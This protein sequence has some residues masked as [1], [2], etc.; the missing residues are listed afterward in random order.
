[1]KAMKKFSFVSLM[2]LLLVQCVVA[3]AYANAADPTNGGLIITDNILKSAQLTFKSSTGQTLNSVTTE[4]IIQVDYTWELLNGHKYVDGATYTFQLPPELEVYEVINDSPVKFNGVE[5]GKFSVA[6]D[7]TAK[8]VFNDFIENNSNIRG[9]LQVLSKINKTAEMNE[10]K[11]VIV[12]PIQG[13]AEQFIPIDFKPGGSAITKNWVRDRDYNTQ[14]VTWTIDLNRNLETINDAVLS[15]I[16]DNPG[17]VPDLSSIVVYNLNS[18]VDG[19]LTPGTVTDA[20]YYEVK[21]AV[22]SNDFTIEFKQPIKSAYRIVYDTSITNDMTN[23][24]NTAKLSGSNYTEQSID[25]TVTVGRGKPLEKM[26]WYDSVTQ[27]VYW[28]IHY[29]YDSKDI[30]QS[31]ALLKDAFNDSNELVVGSIKVEKVTLDAKGNEIPSAT[32]PTTDYQPPVLTSDPVNK[33]N[34]FDLQFNTGVKEPIKITYTTRVKDHVYK[35]TSVGNLVTMGST[36][37]S[38]VYKE[39]SIKQQVLTKTFKSAKYNTKKA[40][41]EII[42]NKAKYTMTNVKLEDTFTNGG[43][44][45]D[46]GSVVIQDATRGALKAGTDYTVTPTANGFSIAFAG[47][48]SD[49]LTITY[50]T[51]FNYDARKDPNTKN[52][53]NNGKF[54]WVDDKGNAQSKE[55]TSTFLPDPYTLAN[56]FKNGS[57]NAESKKITWKIGINYNLQTLTKPSVKDEIIG[58]QAI[59]K[60]SLKV[61]QVSLTGDYNGIGQ[62]T[63]VKEGAGYMVVWDPAGKPGFEVKFTNSINEAYMITYDTSLAGKEI[64]SSYNNTATLYNND[65][66]TKVT[67]LI[68]NPIDVPKGGEYVTKEVQQ[69]GKIA[70]WTININFGQSQV[71]DAVITDVPSDNQSL[72]EDSFQLSRIK[73]MANGSVD[74]KTKLTKG[75]D[76]DLTFQK[77]AAGKDEFVLAFKQEINEPYILTYKSLILAKPGEY[78]SNSVSFSGNNFSLGSVSNSNNFEVKMTTGMGT[79]QGEVGSLTVTKTDR[80]DS[81]KYLEGAEFSLVDA[82]SG[83]VIKKAVTDT[84]GK[85]VFDKLLYGDYLLVEDKAPAGYTININSTTSVTLSNKTQDI[86]ITNAKIDRAVQLTKFDKDKGNIKLQGAT[87][88]LQKYDGSA[89]VK[90]GTYTTDLNGQFTQDKLDPGKYQFVEIAAPANYVLDNTPV[91]FTITSNQTDVT[92]VTHANERGIGFLTVHKQDKADQ[93]ALPGAEFELYDSN[94]YVKTETTDGSGKAVFKDLPYGSYTLKETQAPT[95]YVIDAIES[96][97]TVEVNGTANGENTDVTVANKKI[98]IVM[99]FKLTKVDADNTS[100]VLEG[101]VFQLLYKQ[102]EVDPYVIV[103]GKEALTTDQ[104]GVI[105]GNDLLEG[106]YQLIEV[107][108]PAGYTLDNKPI[109]FKIDKEQTAMKLLEAKNKVVPTNPGTP[110]D[111]TDP[112]TN[113]GTPTDPSD[114]G[115]NGGTTDPGTD[116]GT[117]PG[118]PVDPTDPDQPGNNNGSNGDSNGDNGSG[119]TTTPSQPANPEDSKGDDQ[120]STPD[121]TGQVPGSNKP[122][123]PQGNKGTA[124]TLPQTS[125]ESYNGLTAA[126]IALMLFGITIL[127]YRK[128]NKA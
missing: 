43:M 53:P 17:M 40:S 105:I 100:K 46:V 37:T 41:W 118:T 82:A 29:N 104:N 65:G 11:Q 96:T 95:G 6:M 57:Y 108:A 10:D 98:V 21:P 3:P 94:G 38:S 77:N 66:T 84:N 35:D 15:D 88:E 116:P 12:T 7:G 93:S 64:Q 74:T 117:N 44:T 4:S 124:E 36:V 62:L 78:V 81:A 90:V 110:V 67:D 76:Y 48:V 97:K 79:G 55:A 16:I 113:P 128:R 68:S 22:G 49:S 112:G 27:S 52:L 119:G 109:E 5:I 71:V 85:I 125:G 83:T 102:F 87:F 114:P 33:T 121:Q 20:V 103:A 25:A 80:D 14:N 63:E 60:T 115:N 92:Q 56:G 19:T 32:V 120:T 51:D 39:Q 91:P 126:G 9:T 107:T 18:Q 28:T 99:S 54:S 2:V 72:I 24:K 122:K 70:E 75:V 26:S 101:A 42:F 106:F 30:P 47:T 58:D 69:N 61:Y 8:V 23:Y 86:P 127:F 1:M 34:G 13:G 50:D 73:L 59:D 111:P 45:L 31:E 89:Y 123:D